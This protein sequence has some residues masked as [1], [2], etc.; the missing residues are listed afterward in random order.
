[1]RNPDIIFKGVKEVT[2]HTTDRELAHIVRR[3]L[4]GAADL[5]FGLSNSR[6]D[7]VRFIEMYYPTAIQRFGVEAVRAAAKNVQGCSWCLAWATTRVNDSQ[8]TF[9]RATQ[10]LLGKPCPK[11]L[12]SFKA[13]ITRRVP[14]KPSTPQPPPK[15][16]PTH[17]ASQR[18]LV[19]SDNSLAAIHRRQMA[20]DPAY[21]AKVKRQGVPQMMTDRA[22]VRAVHPRHKRKK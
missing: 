5:D 9:N 3:V 21:R 6:K 7:R 8:L 13:E 14:R 15:P 17:Q 12:R 2:A 18:E 20:T 19:S 4:A 16:Q 10:E 11:C 1:M 22:Q